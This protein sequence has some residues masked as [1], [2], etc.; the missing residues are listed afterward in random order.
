MFHERLTRYRART[1]RC[2]S[3]HSAVLP[4]YCFPPM[5]VYLKVFS[6]LEAAS[7]DLRL[8]PPHCFET[9]LIFWFADDKTHGKPFPKERTFLR[10]QLMRLV[11]VT[12][13]DLVSKE[14]VCCVG[15]KVKHLSK[16]STTRSIT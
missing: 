16:L 8:W 13:E 7:N 6:S 11:H 1:Q 4:D 12:T 3:I 9:T 15:E 5:A 10:M 14:T 2:V